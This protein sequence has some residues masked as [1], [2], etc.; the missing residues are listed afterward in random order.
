MQTATA[1][2]H[3]TMQAVCCIG[4]VLLVVALRVLICNLSGRAIMAIIA[5]L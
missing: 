2:A 1:A 5:G 4:N 3:T